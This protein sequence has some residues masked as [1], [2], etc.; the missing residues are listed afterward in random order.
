MIASFYGMNVNT[1]GM[2]FA[3]M[4]WGFAIVIGISLIISL[5]IAMIFSKKDLFYIR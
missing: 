1:E 4:K 3:D 2:P 5:I